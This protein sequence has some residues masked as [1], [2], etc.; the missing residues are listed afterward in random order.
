AINTLQELLDIPIRHYVCIS[1][2]GLKVLIDAV[3]GIVVDNTIGEFTLD[4]ISVPADKI[5][6]DRTRGF[7][8]ALMRHED[9]L[10]D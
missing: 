4:G 9:P 2:K 10:A 5:K 1:M 3:G 8:Y 6:L 7:A